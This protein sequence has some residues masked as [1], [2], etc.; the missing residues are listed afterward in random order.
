MLNLTDLEQKLDNALEAETQ[1]SLSIWLLEKRSKGTHLQMGNGSY[2]VKKSIS[3][4]YI[5]TDTNEAEFSFQVD[6]QNTVRICDYD[7]KLAA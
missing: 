2:E 1:E 3:F 6:S 7:Y 5:M 4:E